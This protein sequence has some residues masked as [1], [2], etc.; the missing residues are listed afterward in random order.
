MMHNDMT[1][2][3]DKNV[4]SSC[5]P[6]VRRL[7]NHSCLGSTNVPKISCTTGSILLCTKAVYPKMPDFKA[8]SDFVFFAYTFFMLTLYTLSRT[9][10][11]FLL[12]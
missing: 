5:K 1:H 6:F 11:M 10:I 9:L 2:N 7:M 4:Y 12:A 8:N 3:N